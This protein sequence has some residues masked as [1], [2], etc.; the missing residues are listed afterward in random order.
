MTRRALS[1]WVAG[2]LTAGVAT[3]AAMSLGTATTDNN[4]VT[5]ARTT[6]GQLHKRK[7]ARCSGDGGA[8]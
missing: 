8:R 6:R 3:G 1:V 4:R 2:I 7:R 5:C